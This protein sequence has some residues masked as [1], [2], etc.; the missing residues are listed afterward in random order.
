MYPSQVRWLCYFLQLF[1]LTRE[2]EIL[3]AK[4]R[5]ASLTMFDNGHG[6]GGKLVASKNDSL[7]ETCEKLFEEAMPL[8]KS[9]KTGTF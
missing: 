8:S 7:S 2:N 3:A 4:L 5:G 9:L 1:S 6:G